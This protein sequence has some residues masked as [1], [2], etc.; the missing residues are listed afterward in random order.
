M[1]SVSEALSYI[2]DL[3]KKWADQ[4]HEPYTEITYI[5][6]G[7]FDLGFFQKGKKSRAFVSSGSIGKT[8][9]FLQ[10]ADLDRMKAMVDQAVL[11]LNSK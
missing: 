9:A 7:E 2:S 5:S 3:S 8:T 10:T 11:L 1:V 6:K 4:L